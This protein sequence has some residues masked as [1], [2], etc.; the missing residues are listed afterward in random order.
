M[1]FYH[2]AAKQAAKNAVEN[3]GAAVKRVAAKKEP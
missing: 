1:A 2:V 3:R